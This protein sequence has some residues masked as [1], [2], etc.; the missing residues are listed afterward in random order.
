MNL[1][2]DFRACCVTPVLVDGRLRLTA[3]KADF[4]APLLIGLAKER[5]AEIV[6]ALETERIAS[7]DAERHARDRLARRGYDYDRTAPS[8]EGWLRRTVGLSKS[9]DSHDK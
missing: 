6:D 3:A 4:I 7:L 1:L 5:R 8:H 2:D 9:G